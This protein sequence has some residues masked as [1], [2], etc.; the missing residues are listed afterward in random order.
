M[1][2]F[3]GFLLTQ[4]TVFGSNLLHSS[5]HSKEAFPGVPPK[6]LSCLIQSG[7]RISASAHAAVEKQKH[8]FCFPF[9]VTHCHIF[10]TK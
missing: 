7:R 2:L 10:K 9:H 6:P 1:L 8:Y 5:V 4:K 3:G